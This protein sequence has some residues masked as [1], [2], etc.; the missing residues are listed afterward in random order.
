MLS[1]LTVIV[2]PGKFAIVALDGPAPN[3]GD[4]V[5]AVLRE[6]EATT[7][8]ATV[9]VARRKGWSFDFE[10]AWLTLDVHSAL[11]AVGLTAAVA[12]SLAEGGIAC[13]MLAGFYHDHL[14]VPFD[15]ADEAVRCLHGLRS[16]QS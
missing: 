9:E 10:A 5:E 8:V 11:D 4:G 1:E 15:R 13:N 3:L 2:R 7:V 6:N 16:A 14:L 12:S